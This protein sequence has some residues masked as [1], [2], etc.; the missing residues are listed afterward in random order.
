MRS[1][2]HLLIALAS[3]TLCAG[4]EPKDLVGEWKSDETEGRFVTY[5]FVADG[6]FTTTEWQRSSYG[7]SK[8][9]ILNGTYQVDSQQKPA[10]LFLH[11]PEQL[12]L[13]KP[14]DRSAIFEFLKPSVLRMEFFEK[15][16]APP[17]AFGKEAG[18]LTRQPTN[19]TGR[20]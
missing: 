2:K 19:A 12:R 3:F 14:V 9:S 7:T 1:F 16:D 11:I 4:A 10:V 15:R 17:K 13:F 5:T 8:D 20:P 18:V 6:T